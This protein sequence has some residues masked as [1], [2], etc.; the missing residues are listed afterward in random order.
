[1]QVVLEYKEILFTQKG[2][3]QDKVMRPIVKS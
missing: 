1:M 2:L 3:K